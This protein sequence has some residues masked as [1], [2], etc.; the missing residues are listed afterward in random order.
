[1]RVDMPTLAGG[2]IADDLLSRSDTAKFRTS[3]RR[4][5]NGHVTPAGGFFNRPGM[6]FAAEV[7]DSDRKNRVIPFQ[8]SVGQGYALELGHNTLRVV[9]RGGL[10]LRPELIVL[11]ITNA[12]AAVVTTEGPHGYENGWDV[13]FT[14]IE[15]MT[16]INN[17]RGRVTA[18]TTDTFTLNIDTTDFGVFTGSV[19]GI[20]GDAL[21]DVGG[22]PAPPPLPPPPEPSTAPPP[23]PAPFY[24][25][26]N[27]PYIYGGGGYGGLQ[28]N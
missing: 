2:E 13:V 15:G 8:F 9:T 16:E 21:G 1:M 27:N 3:L 4:A 20:A 22:Y 24:D 17:M 18:H 6:K 19:G 23:P 5:R 11:G 12:A 10:V 25:Y 14:E 28:V 7:H 26:E